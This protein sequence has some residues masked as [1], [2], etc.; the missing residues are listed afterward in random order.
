MLCLRG[1]GV[2]RVECHD[3]L[4]LGRRLVEKARG[5][6]KVDYGV[7]TEDAFALLLRSD[8]DRQI[9]PVV[10]VGGDGVAPVLV[11]SNVLRGVVLVKQVPGAVAVDET[12]GVVHEVDGGRKV[13]LRSHGLRV[14]GA[15]CAHPRVESV[16]CRAQVKWVDGRWH[17]GN[18]RSGDHGT[19]G[20]DDACLHGGRG[21]S[22]YS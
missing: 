8:G 13:N 12:V 3:A 6:F 21:R 16:A 2:E 15:Y 20:T 5:V 19:K 18:A 9:L 14:Y 7:T 1:G 10:K 17:G 22:S 11:S 4:V